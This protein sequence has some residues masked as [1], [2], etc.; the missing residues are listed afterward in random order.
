MDDVENNFPVLSRPVLQN[1]NEQTA[2]YVAF[3]T[4]HIHSIP[5]A[6][7]AETLVA[8]ALKHTIQ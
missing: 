1:F 3:L 5:L 2:Q 4:K 6:F 7:K 8:V